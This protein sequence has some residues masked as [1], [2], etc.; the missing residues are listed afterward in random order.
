[1][2]GVKC[3]NKSTINPN[4]PLVNGTSQLGG[5]SFLYH[6][7]GVSLHCQY[8]SWDF[9]P[10]FPKCSKKWSEV[11]SEQHLEMHDISGHSAFFADG[12]AWVTLWAF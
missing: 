6:E 8:H 11:S 4:L 12:A 3:P 7:Q 9:L 2:N 10:L 5:V 1:M